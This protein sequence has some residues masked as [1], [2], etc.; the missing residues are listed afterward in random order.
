MQSSAELSKYFMLASLIH[1]F[2][3]LCAM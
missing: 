1:L 3:I 2:L